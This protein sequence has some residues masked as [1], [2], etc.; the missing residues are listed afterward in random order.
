MISFCNYGSFESMGC[1]EHGGG[2]EM[3]LPQNQFHIISTSTQTNGFSF[4]LLP[5]QNPSVDRRLLVLCAF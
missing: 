5:T 2:E 3:F 1:I 4:R